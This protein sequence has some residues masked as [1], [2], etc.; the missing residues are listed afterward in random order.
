MSDG[1]GKFR[2]DVLWNFGS[3]AVLGVSGIALNTL[4]ASVYDAAALGVFN[5]VWAPYVIGSQLAV[6]GI[7]LSVLK[8]VAAGPK[9]RTHVA[10][11]VVGALVPT[12]VLAAVAAAIFWLAA[13]LVGAF[14]ES[15]HVA[16]GV[17]WAAPGLF[18]FAVNK[19][20]FGVVNGLRRM[21]AFALLQSARFLLMLAGFGVVVFAELGAPRVAFL[22]TFAEGLLLVLLAL[23]VGFQVAW[24]SAGGWR[25]WMPRHVAYG[26]KSALSGVM[27]ELNTRVDIIMLGRY[28]QDAPVGVYSFASMIAEGVFQ[29]MVKLQNNYNPLI[30]EHVALG[31]L[32]ELEALVKRGRVW[33]WLLM[34]GVG[35]VAIAGY[36][37]GLAIL[38]TRDA[39]I[40]GWLAFGILIGGIFL[41]AGYMPFQQ[42]LLMAGRPGWHTVMMIVMVATNVVGNA[43]LIPHFELAGAA[44]ASAI[45]M[46][47]S[48]LVLRF[49]VRVQVGA[50]I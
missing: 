37:L 35:S 18:C 23:E 40:G 29:L 8:E 5:Q 2:S 17:R 4:I 38:G 3:I 9:E 6:G 43:L 36:P 12:V 44:A 26:A 42:T 30:A 7:D 25:A 16:T 11:A 31:R 41:S 21:R 45:A 33:S 39:M 19:V 10:Q 50:R 1:H 27:A 32:R 14:Y 34:L 46:V 13:G 48:V 24:R 49:F 22:F 20:L 47:V 15:E 28:L